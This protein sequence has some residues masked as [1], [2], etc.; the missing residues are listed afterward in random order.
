MLLSGGM[1]LRIRL[2]D[3]QFLT[4]A[5]RN[6]IARS[7]PLIMDLL[8]QSLHLDFTLRGTGLIH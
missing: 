4:A 8:Q 6:F 2:A 3:Q 7:R 1:P 5:Q